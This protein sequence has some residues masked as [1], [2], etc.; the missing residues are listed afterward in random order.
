MS[1]KS[2]SQLHKSAATHSGAAGFEVLCFSS[3]RRRRCYCKQSSVTLL[4]LQ[5]SGSPIYL[6]SSLP[7][8]ERYSRLGKVPKTMIWKSSGPALS[9]GASSIRLIL[10]SKL[11]SA[12]PALGGGAGDG[13]GDLS[14]DEVALVLSG[15]IENQRHPRFL[16]GLSR[17]QFINPLR[18][19]TVTTPPRQHHRHHAARTIISEQGFWEEGSFVRESKYK[20]AYDHRI[21]RIRRENEGQF[22]LLSRQYLFEQLRAAIA[23]TYYENLGIEEDDIFVSDGAKS[24]ISRLQKF[25]RIGMLLMVVDALDEIFWRD[26]IMPSGMMNPP[27]W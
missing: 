14:S 18:E 16:G 15:P 10:D 9:W 21:F 6:V 5:K 19:T 2:S 3:R 7:E 26:F 11:P 13:C 4:Q 12:F 20:G 25:Y 23:K 24:D 27:T 1:W 17:Y 8:T 22:C